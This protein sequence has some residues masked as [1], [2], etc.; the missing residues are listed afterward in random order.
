M[1]ALAASRARNGRKTWPT[2]ILPAGQYV[3]LVLLR[4]HFSA[5]LH[6]LGMIH[7]AHATGIPGAA[8]VGHAATLRRTGS[9]TLHHGSAVLHH[10]VVI[11]LTHARVVH[12]PHAGGAH[13][14]ALAGR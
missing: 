8:T 7:L 1:L 9:A 4:H 14:P 12:L 10:L 2:L 3:A 11:H 6:H 5:V 13:G